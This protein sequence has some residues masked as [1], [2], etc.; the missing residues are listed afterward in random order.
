MSTNTEAEGVDIP[1]TVTYDGNEYEVL[2]EGSAEILNIKKPDIQPK[3]SANGQTV[4]YNPIQQFNRDLS[5]LAIRAFGEDFATIRRLRYEKRSLKDTGQ[6][7]GKKRKR[8]PECGQ[9][10]NGVTELPAESV[11]GSA[12]TNP[13]TVNLQHH[14][15]DAEMVSSSERKEAPVTQDPQLELAPKAPKAELERENRPPP[16][17]VCNSCLHI[18]Q[19]QTDSL[20]SR[21]SGSLMLCPQPGSELCVTQKSSKW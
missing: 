16:K 5:V 1:N 4:F 9:Q 20:H 19:G 7:R 11:A 21:P 10:S 18:H 13:S 14:S 8:G 15:S 17:P 2:R 6:Q 12:D 3:Q